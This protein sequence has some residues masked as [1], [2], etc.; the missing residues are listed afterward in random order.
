MRRDATWISHP[1]GLAGTPSVGHCVAEASSASCTASSAA[2]KSP[3]RRESTPTTCG[4]SVRSRSSALVAS[5]H[6]SSA[7][8]AITERT[9]IGMFSGRPPGPGAADTAS[10]SSTTRYGVSQSTIHH[11]ARN[12]LVSGTARH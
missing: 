10:A 1:L 2:S 12:S 4:A 9:S 6:S 5:G 7:G 11:P 3:K 8:A